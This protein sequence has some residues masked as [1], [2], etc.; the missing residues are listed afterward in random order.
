MRCGLSFVDVKRREIQ[1]MGVHCAHKIIL[2]NYTRIVLVQ[3]V[4][5]FC[6]LCFRFACVLIGLLIQKRVN[7]WLLRM[8]LNK[9]REKNQQ[10]NPFGDD[11]LWFLFHVHEHDVF[12]GLLR[13][14]VVATAVVVMVVLLLMF[15]IVVAHVK[16]VKPCEIRNSNNKNHHVVNTLHT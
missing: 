6:C 1:W 15:V 7:L 5:M 11:R 2:I 8:N 10:Q 9:R 14:V 12:I 3:L 13:V 4:K 16:R